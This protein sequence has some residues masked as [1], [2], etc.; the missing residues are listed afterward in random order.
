MLSIVPPA[1]HATFTRA[2]SA[3]HCSIPRGTSVR[4]RHLNNDWTAERGRPRGDPKRKNRLTLGLF[5]FLS[6]FFVSCDSTNEPP[7]PP[8]PTWSVG[9]SGDV[10]EIGYGTGTSF[11]QYA[12]LHL[13]SSYLRLNYGPESTWGTSIIL[14]PAFWSG[15]TY[16]QG[17]P[18]THSSQVPGSNLILTVDGAIAGIPFAARVE[19]SPPGADAMTASVSVSAQGGPPVDSRPGEAFKLVML[20][21]MYIDGD[22]WDARAA[23]VG[24]GEYPI[25][26]SGFLIASPLSAERFGLLGGTSG[27]QTSHGA[28][29]AP[30]VI[31]DLDRARQVW[32]W[33][34]PSADPNDDNV[35][36]W[37]AADTFVPSWSYTITARR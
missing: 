19:L 6:F 26:A 23:V 14:A 29:N 30:T 10:V 25:P 37:A 31:I 24:A 20:S 13:S 1:P 12:A 15:G 9:V 4:T 33:V 34:T 2:V 32:G 28:A 35:G 22:N 18:V 21:S 36:M 17:A 5:A 27:W 7:P 8:E 3:F 16:Y 11:P